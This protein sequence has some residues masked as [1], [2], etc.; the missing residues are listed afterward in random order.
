MHDTSLF[1][2]ILKMRGCFGARA[3]LTRSSSEAH[4]A[5]PSFCQKSSTLLGNLRGS[6]LALYLDHEH[7]AKSKESTRDGARKARRPERRTRTGGKTQRETA[8]RDCP[9]GCHC[10]VEEMQRYCCL[11]IN[12]FPP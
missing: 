2:Y 4:A 3:F 8:P 12:T 6:A 9:P 10:A 11:W 1:P 7:G 5:Q